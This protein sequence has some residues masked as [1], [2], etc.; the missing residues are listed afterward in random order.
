MI[1]QFELDSIILVAKIQHETSLR[2]I[3]SLNQSL[4]KKNQNFQNEKIKLEIVKTNTNK[5]FDSINSLNNQIDMLSKVN[6]SLKK[7]FLELNNHSKDIYRIVKI[8]NQI[9]SITNITRSTFNNGDSIRNAKTDE[10]W[11]YCGENRIPAYCIKPNVDGTTEYFYNWYVVGDK[12]GILPSDFRIPT[13]QDLIEMENTVGALIAPSL[14]AIGKW[15]N[16]QELDDYSFGANPIFI[17]E[18]NG[19]YTPNI[20][21]IWT[22][23]E[24]SEH[25]AIGFT[26]D[27]VTDYP[28][29]SDFSKAQGFLI[30]AIK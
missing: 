24:I 2:Y 21:G 16:T 7:V 15:S 6:D 23:T 27:D 13:N 19:K 22:S 30:R 20:F 10:E 3:D 17:R 1:Q 5:I 29:R 26:L 9:W 14:K 11:K 8:N 28:H 25:S 18:E 4:I 12:R